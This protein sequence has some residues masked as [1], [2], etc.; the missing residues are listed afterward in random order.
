[1]ILTSLLIAHLLGD[2]F[3]QTASMAEKKKKEFKS[4]LL[5]SFLYFLCLFFVFILFVETSYV[6][7]PL[8]LLSFLH[9]F[10]DFAK[11]K[12][13]RRIL[14]KGKEKSIL[15]CSF[16][17]DQSL[18]LLT[19][20][21]IYSTWHLEKHGS[22]FYQLHYHSKYFHNGA[23]YLLMFLTILSPSAIFI[24]KM[25]LLIS[26]QEEGNE[27]SLR[28]GSLIGKLE[29]IIIV[30]FLLNAQYG[31]IGLVLA[32]KSIAR[33]KQM[34]NKD[35]AEKYLVGTLAS[36]LLALVVSMGLKGYLIS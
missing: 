9:F 23:L 31:A 4:L 26:K 17:I 25:F 8:L 28:I 30:L 27:E 15:F 19:I 3:F 10:I 33:F 5:H 16:L 36:L 32:A 11:E 22:T 13:E 29:R 18:H 20:V 7:I 1:M 2:F 21:F 6:F 12:V 14:E 24:K 35:F 34:D